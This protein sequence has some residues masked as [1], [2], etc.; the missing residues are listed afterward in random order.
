MITY[1]QYNFCR[2]IGLPPIPHVERYFSASIIPLGGLAGAGVGAILARNKI[3]RENKN[4]NE[5]LTKDEVKKI[6]RKYALGG[7]AIGGG[8][9][10]GVYGLGKTVGKKH[11]E[12]MMKENPE[13]FDPKC[14][15]PEA[16][17]EIVEQFEKANLTTVA[18]KKLPI[19]LLDKQGMSDYY[20]KN[21]K[22]Y[23]IKQINI[24]SMINS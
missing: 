22:T 13:L 11:L 10:A 19:K 21:K 24:P 8:L 6:F 14:M 16:Y 4:R 18:G 5:P 7:A 17:K 20:D 15:T 3:K 2:K 23:N 12:K 1:K 9:G